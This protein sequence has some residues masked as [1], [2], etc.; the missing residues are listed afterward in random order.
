MQALGDDAAT[1][2][3]VAAAAAGDTQAFGALVRLHQARVRLQ[4]RRLLCGRSELAD[5]LAQDTFVIAW[6]QRAAFR[7][8]ARW[9]SWLYRIAWTRFL[10]WKRAHREEARSLEPHAGLQDDDGP[11]SAAESVADPRQIDP[12]LRLDLQ[13]ALDRLP[14]AQRAAVV[15]CVQLEMSHEEA[16]RLLGQPLGTLKSNV[17]RGTARLR[18]C[19]APWAGEAK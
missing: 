19:L 8:E 2:A 6:R 11:W 16:S 5:E 7:G 3:L 10:M 12:V 17:A 18:A 1:R 9:S 13:R 15:H 14:L 4:L